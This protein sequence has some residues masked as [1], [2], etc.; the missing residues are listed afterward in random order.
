MAGSLTAVEGGLGTHLLERD[1]CSPP[2]QFDGRAG[3]TG[4]AGLLTISG[5]GIR[6]QMPM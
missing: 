4:L 2:L 6:V 1:L 5:L 3:I